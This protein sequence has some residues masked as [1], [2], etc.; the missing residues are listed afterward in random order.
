MKKQ[1]KSRVSLRVILTGM[2]M[3][4]LILVGSAATLIGVFN[5]RRGMEEEVETGVAAACKSY[6]MVLEYTRGSDTSLDELESDMNEK[7][8]YDYTYFE[9]D[10]RARSSI[11]GVV[12]TKAGDAIIEAVLKN[13]ESY[14]AQNVVI[15]GEKYYV[16]YEPLVD[17]EGDVYGMAFVGK[18]KIQ[19]TTYINNRIKLMVTVAGVF[20]ILGTVIAVFYVM[21]IIKAIQESVSAVRQMASGDLSISLSEKVRKRPDE[22]G[23]M[24]VAIYDM[25]ERVRSVISNARDSSVEVDNSAEYLYSTVQSIS[26][27]A[28][29]VTTSVSQVASGATSQAESLQN[30]VE[31]INDINDAIQLIS[32][33]THQMQELADSMQQNSTASQDKLNELRNST[34]ESIEAIEVIV[35]MIGNTNTAVNTISEAVSFIDDIAAQTNLLSLNASIEAAR[36]GEAGKGFAVVAEEIR[37]LADQSADAANNIQEAMKGLSA[38]SNKTM[39]EAGIVQEAINNQRSTIHR[40]IEQVDVLIDDID[41][42]VELTKDIV[43]SVNKSEA[44]CSTISDTVTSLSAIS[45]ENAA[46]SESTRLSMEDLNGT[47]EDLSTKASGLNDIAKELDEEMSFFQ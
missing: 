13:K 11:E 37:Q 7:T 39:H 46:S 12:G 1:D 25:A 18:K 3:L 26:E 40:T 23:E 15:N 35:D 31:G 36:A 5:L 30:A 44:A 17:D 24:S 20:V 42:S 22:I 34:R 19:I 10:T 14:Q 6:A 32:D 45:E 9:G 8:G 28:Q 27:T 43:N 38:D 33:N 4:S 41:K 21:Q 2:V 47:M 16:A 29:N